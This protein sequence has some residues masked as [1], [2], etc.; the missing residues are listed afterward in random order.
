MPSAVADSAGIEPVSRPVYYGGSSHGRQMLLVLL[1]SAVVAGLTFGAYK[2]FDGMAR[3]KDRPAAG[4]GAV[5]LPTPNI[6]ASA[7]KID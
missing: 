1:L 7:L 6:R 4:S 2:V 5:R 3:R